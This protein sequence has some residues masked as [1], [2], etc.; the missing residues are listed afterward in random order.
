MA[1]RIL[2]DTARSASVH[3]R[4]MRMLASTIC[5][6]TRHSRMPRSYRRTSSPSVIE[7][8][9]CG[10]SWNRSV[11]CSSGERAGVAPAE[12]PCLLVPLCA[13][14]EAAA[15]CGAPDGTTE[16]EGRAMCEGRQGDAGVETE[17]MSAPARA[18]LDKY[19][20]PPGVV[21]LG[22]GA[23]S[24]LGSA[25]SLLTGTEAAA[26]TGD[27]RLSLSHHTMAAS[28]LLTVTGSDFRSVRLSFDAGSEGVRDDEREAVTRAVMLRV[29]TGGS[30]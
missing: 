12:A 20:T 30:D 17:A 21:A 26:E 27:G 25:W 5:S 7:S 11:Y 6:R 19:G 29:V 9:S 2:I 14:D 4:W 3:E 28:K 23:Q 24:A 16:G 13:A 8:Y 15:C 1:L 10:S 18:S 22:C